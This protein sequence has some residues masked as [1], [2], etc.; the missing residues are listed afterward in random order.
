M[1]D[2]R[3]SGGARHPEVGVVR[4]LETDAATRICTRWDILGPTTRRRRLWSARARTHGTGSRRSDTTKRE[5][6]CTRAERSWV[7]GSELPEQCVILERLEWIER[8]NPP[9]ERNTLKRFE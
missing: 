3:G 2:G 7:G 9:A 4:P 6:L 5:V 8:D 1:F